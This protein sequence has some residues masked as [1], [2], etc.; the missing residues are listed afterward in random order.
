MCFDTLKWTEHLPI[1]LLGLRSTFKQDIGSSPSQMVYGTVLKLPGEMFIDS[2]FKPQ[3]EFVK[4]FIEL[5][6]SVR[7]ADTAH[8]SI[9]KPFIN[10]RLNDAT[11]VFIRVDKVR[12]SFTPPY[13][14]PFEIKKCFP[15]FYKILVG[16]R[17]VN[18]SVD[19]LKPAFITLDKADSTT[20][21][22]T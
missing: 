5:M 14:D 6:R 9:K 18:I 1:V 10:S 3:D 16:D 19:R 22:S 8:H 12:Y 21:N 17:P 20:S 11:H 15:K 7:P 2:L 13:D 4:E